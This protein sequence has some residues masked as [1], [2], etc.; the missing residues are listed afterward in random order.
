MPLEKQSLQPTLFGIED[1]TEGEI[2]TDKQI[3]EKYTGLLMEQITG[4]EE[5]PEWSD[6][7]LMLRALG[8]DFRK[9]A[10]I[11]WKATPKSKRKPKTQN[12]LATNILGLTSDRVITTW[13]EKN[14]LIDE[15]VNVLMTADL[16]EH[17]AAVFDAL[18]KSAAN[19]DYKHHPDRKLFLEI[20]GDYIP[21]SQLKAML[22]SG[23]LKSNKALEDYSEA[24]LIALSKGDWS[25]LGHSDAEDETEGDA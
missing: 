19:P 22:T 24:E 2:E 7:Y 11:A 18:K 12:D 21:I 23:Q 4:E 17:R 14:P 5:A 9:A 20:T 25:V 8:W 6:R 10:Y 3:V 13:R 15:A 1:L 16:Y